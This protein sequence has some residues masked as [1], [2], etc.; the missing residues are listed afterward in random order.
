MCT[1]NV[2]SSVSGRQA[3]DFLPACACI[4]IFMSPLLTS[5][6]G[7]DVVCPQEQGCLSLS[8]WRLPWRLPA[9]PP[10]A[11]SG[12]AQVG[13]GSPS[14]GCVSPGGEGQLPHQPQE[15][16]SISSAASHGCADSQ[17]PVSPERP[18]TL[19]PQDWWPAGREPLPESSELTRDG[20]R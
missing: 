17:A 12:I 11:A 5:P 13:R 2:G 18:V 19:S 20:P 16:G 7:R 6:E 1:A 3:P 15:A 14:P 8:P 9:F 10:Q 4:C